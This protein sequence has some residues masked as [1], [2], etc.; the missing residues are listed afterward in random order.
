MRTAN[1]NDNMINAKVGNQ[2]KKKYINGEES[3][4][5]HFNVTVPPKSAPK[6]R[7]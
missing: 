2:N 3:V 6:D 4:V 1:V 5:E 7:K